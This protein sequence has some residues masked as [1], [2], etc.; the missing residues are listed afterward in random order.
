MALKWKSMGNKIGRRALGSIVSLALVTG[1]SACTSD[2]DVGYLYVTSPKSTIP[3]LIN[4][5]KV[6]YQTGTLVPLAEF[7]RSVGRQESGQG[8][9]QTP[10]TTK[11]IYVIHRDDSSVVLFAIGTDGKLYPQ[12]DLRCNVE[13]FRPPSQWIQP[14]AFSM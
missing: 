3:G 13:A 9:R 10:K 7:A 12:S 14:T 1:M 4:G 8:W 5:Y 2:Y 11:F 6:D